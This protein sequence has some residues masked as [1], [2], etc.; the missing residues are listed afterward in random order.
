MWVWLDVLKVFAD[1]GRGLVAAYEKDLIHRDFKPEN[2]MIGAD[3]HVRVMDFG[4]VRVV[5]VRDASFGTPHMAV[6]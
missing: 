4:L 2:V 3:G 1:A 6:S 5:I